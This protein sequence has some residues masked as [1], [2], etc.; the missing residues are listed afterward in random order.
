MQ[1]I[2]LAVLLL[3]VSTRPLVRAPG[4]YTESLACYTTL[5]LDK[6]GLFRLNYTYVDVCGLMPGRGCRQIFR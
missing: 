6:Y 3:T 1:S 5:G 2:D 4:T